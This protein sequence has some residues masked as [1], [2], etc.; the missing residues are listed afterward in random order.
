M[1]YEAHAL[2]TLHTPD[3][4]LSAYYSADAENPILEAPLPVQ[5][6][7]W[8]PNYD[9]GT[10]PQYRH[11]DEAKARMRT[12]AE[13]PDYWT[14][15]I[16]AYEHGNISLH[17]TEYSQVN[18]GNGTSKEDWEYQIDGVIAVRREDAVL[19]F[20]DPE[21]RAELTAAYMQELVKRYGYWLNGDSGYTIRVEGKCSHCGQAMPADAMHFEYDAV[22]MSPED[23]LED[24]RD[25]CLP[26]DRRPAA[27]ETPTTAAAA[28]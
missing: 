9:F 3:Y 6:T 20:P 8:L 25:T 26:A 16:V 13:N 11:K 12:L 18:G 10:E 24:C 15:P 21:T 2:A 4:R 1:F 23:A 17:T 27:V 7:G 22:N 5:V 28:A 14:L 19:H